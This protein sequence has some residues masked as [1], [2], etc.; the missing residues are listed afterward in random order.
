MELFNFY[1]LIVA[2]TATLLIIVYTVTLWRDCKGSNYKFINL[3]VVI[4][5]LGNICFLTIAF[6]EFKLFVLNEIKPVYVWM[7]SLCSGGSD[8]AL[9]LSHILLAFKYR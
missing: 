8:L 4:L 1:L 9:C 3:I 2:L 7:L 6:T 5:L